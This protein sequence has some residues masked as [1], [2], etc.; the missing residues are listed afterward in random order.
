MEFQYISQFFIR[1]RRYRHGEVDNSQSYDPHGAGQRCKTAR[2]KERIARQQCCQTLRRYSF[3]NS[4]SSGSN[5]KSQNLTDQTRTRVHLYTDVTTSCQDRT[6][7]SP[8]SRGH[9][10]P[11]LFGD[12]EGFDGGTTLNNADRGKELK[13]KLTV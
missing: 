10:N 2:S 8:Q 7:Q 13:S 3:E 4:R 12:C 6:T 5:R 11:L 9:E 1:H